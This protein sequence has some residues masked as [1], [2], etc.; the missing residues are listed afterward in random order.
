MS[1][2]V[3]SARTLPLW[4]LP[5]LAALLPFVVSHLAWWLSVREGLMPACNPYWDGC[6]SIS[7]AARHGLGNHLFRMVMLPCATLQALCWL[8]A[9]LWL[10]RQWQVRVRVLPWLGLAAGVFLALY[11]T[12]LG[13]DGAVYAAAAPLRR[14]PVLRLQ[15]PRAAGWCC[16]RCRGCSRGHAPTRR[17]W[18][19]RWDSWRWA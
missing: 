17:C 18:W 11:A 4:P 8:A 2:S 5:L 6:V 15:L 19:S 12:F 9:T 1:P 7:R 16:T 10:R 3:P 14:V 13:S